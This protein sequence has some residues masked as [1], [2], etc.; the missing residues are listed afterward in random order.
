MGQGCWWLFGSHLLGILF[1]LARL[2]ES[3]L[4]VGLADHIEALLRVLPW[5]SLRNGIPSARRM[6]LRSIRIKQSFVQNDRKI[7][8]FC[9]RPDQVRL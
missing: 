3:I 2:S 8:S 1:A 7:Y 5:H 6:I 4:L 9:S